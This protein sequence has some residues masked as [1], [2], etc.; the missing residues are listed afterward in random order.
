MLYL[1]MFSEKY[2]KISAKIKFAANFC[3]VF[4]IRQRSPPGS[5]RQLGRYVDSP[6]TLTQ[7][8]FSINVYRTTVQY[9]EEGVMWGREGKK[10]G[11]K[12]EEVCKKR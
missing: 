11:K 6:G 9:N 1:L 5:Y 12:G 10:G 3:T 7:E 2:L 4:G 8:E